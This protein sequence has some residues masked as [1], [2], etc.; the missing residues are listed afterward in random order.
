MFSLEDDDGWGAKPPSKVEK[1]SK[2]KEEQPSLINLSTPEGIV[3]MS[4][5]V[6]FI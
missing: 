4:Q 5:N 2:P 3:S 6:T 1:K